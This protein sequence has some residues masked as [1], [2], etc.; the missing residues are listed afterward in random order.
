MNIFLKTLGAIS[1]V[2]SIFA[3]EQEERPCKKQKTEEQQE[4]SVEIRSQEQEIQEPTLQGSAFQKLPKEIILYIIEH[5]EPEEVKNVADTCRYLR[6]TIN[7]PEFTKYLIN[8]WVKKI[9]EQG[10]P[11]LET[12]LTEKQLKVLTP[13]I[14]AA[15]FLRTDS[16]IDYLQEKYH[17]PKWTFIDEQTGNKYERE[18]G[19][20][21][22]DALILTIRYHSSNTAFKKKIFSLIWSL[23]RAGANINYS[24]LEDDQDGDDFARIGLD[25]N[26]FIESNEF[27]FG[28]AI[29]RLQ[30]TTLEFL[31]KMGAMVSD[32]QDLG[33]LRK[34][35]KK[36]DP[37]TRLALFELIH[38]VDKYT[39]EKRYLNLY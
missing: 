22:T 6:V 14:M 29:K 17:A 13:D 34:Y 33:Q 35:A 23:Q 19:Q 4:V 16:A 11:Y 25:M 24:V 38:S 28:I 37:D 15:G 30:K 36:Q 18:D 12:Q 39:W 27:P 21:L 31:L 7:N 9:T 10:N 26:K 20:A 3:M 32:N 5:V 8:F 2:G 1:L